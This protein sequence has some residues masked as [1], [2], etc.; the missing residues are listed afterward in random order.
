MVE[1]YKP[2][3]NDDLSADSDYTDSDDDVELVDLSIAVKTEPGSQGNESVYPKNDMQKLDTQSNDPSLIKK[4][5]TINT[6][7]ASS[8]LQKLRTTN[9]HYHSCEFKDNEIQ[10]CCRMKAETTWDVLL[11]TKTSGYSI[12]EKINRN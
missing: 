10:F 4:H 8:I 11:K 9:L 2:N 6:K 7:W 5:S 1:D 3:D 12:R